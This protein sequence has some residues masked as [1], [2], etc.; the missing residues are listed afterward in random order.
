MTTFSATTCKTALNPLKHVKYTKGMVL[1]VEDFDQDF[2]YGHAHWRWVN[3]D[4]LGFG[5]VSGLKV[6]S[7]IGT[8]GPRVRVSKGVALNEKGEMICVQ[9]D[10]CAYL[11]KWL[12]VPENKAKVESHIDF[13]GSPPGDL[14]NLHVVLCFEACETDRVPIPGEPCRSE[15]T[16]FAPSRIADGFRLELRLDP[17]P[18]TE[19]AALRDFVQWLA[20]A[21]VTTSSPSSMTMEEFLEA[22]EQA[23]TPPSPPLS[24]PDF[25]LGSPP[26]S[27]EIN[28][29]DLGRYLRGAFRLWV[30]TLRPR[31]HVAGCLKVGPC[32]G[33]EA[34]VPPQP[35]DCLLLATLNVPLTVDREVS[36]AASVTIDEER[37][38]FLLHLQFLQEWALYS[39]GRT[40]GGGEPII[41]AA[42]M[43]PPMMAPPIGRVMGGTGEPAV[44][45]I[46]AGRFDRDGAATAATFGNLTVKRLQPQNIYLLTSSNIQPGKLYTAR[47]T[48]ITTADSV[49]THVLET[50]IVGALSNTGLSAADVER[51]LALRV[52]RGDGQ[53]PTTAYKGFTV[54]ITE[55][56]N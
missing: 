24:P 47:A 34:V 54:E 7:E 55:Y 9:E 22:I 42:M 32:C 2:I 25:F 11:N 29:Q 40:S 43:V 1:G 26:P 44:R 15:E 49:A 5:T 4:V 30:T 53:Q 56:G 31:W 13:A 27:M 50:V 37:R 21:I 6:T 16:A 19:E 23:L 3:A 12:A 8:E 38:P 33:G 39:W 51:T 17:P 35:D 36:D 18:H 10:Q 48:A 14:V 41:P 52:R 45:V 20:Q 28:Q 46:A